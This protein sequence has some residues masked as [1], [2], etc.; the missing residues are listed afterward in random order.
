LKGRHC[1]GR[2]KKEIVAHVKLLPKIVL[3]TKAHVK[4]WRTVT[5]I[6]SRSTEIV[7]SLICLLISILKET[8]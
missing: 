2:L 5:A 8:Y 6:E 4:E 3:F 1:V 7:H